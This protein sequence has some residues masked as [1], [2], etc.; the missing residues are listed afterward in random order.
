LKPK[1]RAARSYAKARDWK[2]QIITEQEIRTPY[3]DNIKFLLR[4]R[5]I[6]VEFEEYDFILKK[7]RDLREADPEA[8]L[9]AC[10]KDPL[11]QAKLLPLIWHLVS[12]KTIQT[13]LSLPLSMHSRIWTVS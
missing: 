11:N 12:V 10:Y 7:L 6:S 4:Y 3:L 8:L 13:D 5:S 2:F 9:K 1:F